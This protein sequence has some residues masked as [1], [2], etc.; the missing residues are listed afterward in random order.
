MHPRKLNIV[1]KGSVMKLRDY[2]SVIEEYLR[3]NKENG[4]HLCISD[5]AVYGLAKFLDR[6]NIDIKQWP[7]TNE[8]FETLDDLPGVQRGLMI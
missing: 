1:L 4:A 8:W 3:R 5:I 2:F 6:I 7:L